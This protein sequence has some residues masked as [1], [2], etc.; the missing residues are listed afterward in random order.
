MIKKVLL[1]FSVS[2]L[3]SSCIGIEQ[4]VTINP[5]NSGNVAFTYTIAK[6]FSDFGS[7][8]GVKKQMPLPVHKADFERI[9]KSTKGLTLKAYSSS[10]TE[11][12][13]VIRAELSFASVTDLAA[14][15]VSDEPEIVAAANGESTSVTVSIPAAGE[16]VTDDTLAMAEEM[17]AGY[18]FV[19][20]IRTPGPITNHTLGETGADKKS[21]TWKTTLPRLL[22]SDKKQLMTVTW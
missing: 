20:T 5:D 21:V 14:F 12:N 4:V 13:I 10:E 6:E 19:L 11:K 17:S 3:F 7:Y 8:G 22:E 2:F 15:A 16:V 1:L 9:V 18:E